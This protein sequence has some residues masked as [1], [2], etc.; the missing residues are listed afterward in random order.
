MIRVYSLN[1]PEW[2]F[3]VIGCLG[4]LAAGALQPAWSIVFSKV[5]GVFAIC[6]RDKQKTEIEM[7]CLIFVGFGL[8]VRL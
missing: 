1:R 6:D 2:H 7:Y 3:I 4:S 5:I 8:K